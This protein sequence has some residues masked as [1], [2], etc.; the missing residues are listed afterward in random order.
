MALVTRSTGNIIQA[1]DVDQ[2][3]NALTGV[4]TDQPYTLSYSPGGAGAIPTLKLVSNGNADLLQGYQGVT[5][6]FYVDKTG[7]IFQGSNGYT[8]MVPTIGT[9]GRQIF[10]GTTTP[11][12]ANEGDIWIKA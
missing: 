1:T 12:G 8:V 10:V 6:E 7:A 2:F 9:A 11:T 4:M 5:K 3:L